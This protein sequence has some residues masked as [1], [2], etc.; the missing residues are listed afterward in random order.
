M[1]GSELVARDLQRHPR[2]KG[3]ALAVLGAFGVATPYLGY[4]FGIQ[5]HVAARVELVD[6]V[7]PGLAI[8][9]SGLA[10]CSHRVVSAGPGGTGYLLRVGLVALA[11]SAAFWMAATHVPLLVEASRSGG[12][13]AA[14]WHAAAGV[15]ATAWSAVV[16]ASNI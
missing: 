7:A 3:I 5:V 15:L 14:I 9:I 6:H 13:G 2:A 12:W 8:A 11:F 16:Y 4:L 10:L 1:A